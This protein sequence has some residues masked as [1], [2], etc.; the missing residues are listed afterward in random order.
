MNNDDIKNYYDSRYTVETTETFPND[1]PRTRQMLAEILQKTHGGKVLDIGCGVGYALDFFL[2]QE[3]EVYGVDISDAAIAIARQRI[4]NGKFEQINNDDPLPYATSFFDAIICL[5]VL[6]HVMQPEKL[7]S[8]CFRVL[9]PNGYMCF[10]V[11]NSISPHYKLFSG[12]EQIYEKP[13]TS[14]EWHALFAASQFEIIS[15]RK[16]I[17]PTIH[18]AMLLK[19]KIKIFAHKF[20]NMLPMKYTYQFIFFIR[21]H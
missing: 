1:V 9:K 18:P 12:T 4:K 5:G 17:G 11:P 13:R 14:A 16:D 20:L 10:V 19:K 8:E 21:K 6:E 2:E 7:L 15:T 3:S